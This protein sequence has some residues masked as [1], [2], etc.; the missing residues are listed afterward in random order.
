M[1]RPVSKYLNRILG[2]ARVKVWHVGTYLALVLL[3][4]KN[5]QSSPFRVTRRLIMQMSRARSRTTYHKCLRELE[6]LGY[7]KYLPSYHPNEASKVWIV[8]S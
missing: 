4:D 5:K 2:D 3:W 7:I 8:D 6:N 1:E